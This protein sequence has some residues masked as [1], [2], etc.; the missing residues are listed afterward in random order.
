M[1]AEKSQET[2]N[3][4]N[5][6]DQSRNVYIKH[7]WQLKRRTRVSSH[8]STQTSLLQYCQLVFAFYATRP[9]TTFCIEL[10][11][12]PC[13]LH[14]AFPHVLD[15]ARKVV[16][17]V[18]LRLHRLQATQHWLAPRHCMQTSPRT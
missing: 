14:K 17:A 2:I 13:Q 10:A 7:L 4:D 6:N 5:E 15:E 1:P 11:V 12:V 18:E 3:E 9:A 8:H 16:V